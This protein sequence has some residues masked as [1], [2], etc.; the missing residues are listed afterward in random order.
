[1]LPEVMIAA[2][3]PIGTTVFTFSTRLSVSWIFGKSLI[4]G[5]VGEVAHLPE[6]RELVL[7]AAE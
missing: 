4:A 7:R 6:E 2:E 1:M 3:M 5:E